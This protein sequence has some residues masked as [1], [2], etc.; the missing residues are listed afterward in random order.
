MRLKTPLQTHLSRPYSVPVRVFSIVSG[1]LH[2]SEESQ[3]S[4]SGFSVLTTGPHQ[5]VSQVT[6]NPGGF[7][8]SFWRYSYSH[9]LHCRRSQVVESRSL[10]CRPALSWKQSRGKPP[11][12]VPARRRYP[13]RAP[14]FAPA[15]SIRGKV[16]REKIPTR[17]V[18][19]FP[20]V[21]GYPLKTTE[22][23][24]LGR[25]RNTKNGS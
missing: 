12:P 18:R 8:L 7:Y 16:V 4:F 15:G 9:G 19:R 25:S 11:F 22:E 14:K 3:A 21:Y 1:G 20:S 24:Q 5:R 6:L 23:G 13:N 10:G 2:F 17:R